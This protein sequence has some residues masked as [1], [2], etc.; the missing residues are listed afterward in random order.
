MQEQPEIKETAENESITPSEMNQHESR[1]KQHL[2]KQTGRNILL[3]VGGLVIIGIVIVVFGTQILIGFSLLLEKM[4]GNDTTPTVTKEEKSYIAPPILDPAVDA[5]NSAQIVISGSAEKKQTIYLYINDQL[6]NK[7][8]VRSNNSF[9]FPDVTL[10]N[11]QNEIKVKAVTQ[12]RQESSFS[13]AI[14]ISFL[15]EEPSLSIDKPQ[16]GQGFNKSSGPVNIEGQT[17]P[18]VQITVNDFVA[19]VDDQ[20]KFSYLYTLKDGENEIKVVATDDAGNKKTQ[21]LRIHTN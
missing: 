3:V 12:D 8:S 15:K 1:L 6:V 19:I 20:G 16:D 13:Q 5:T 4:R 9:N 10:E 17:D 18:G 11:G 21:D 7:T 2:E 14:H